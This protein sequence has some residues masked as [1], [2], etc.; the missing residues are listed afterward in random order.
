MKVH[1]HEKR[2]GR[3]L[4][5]RKFGCA[6]ARSTPD[7]IRKAQPPHLMFELEW[8]FCLSCNMP[9]WILGKKIE[10]EELATSP[11][12]FLGWMQKVGYE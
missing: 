5:K 8:Q 7:N 2:H 6:I 1:R 9:H 4:D 10:I 11:S 3:V 12:P